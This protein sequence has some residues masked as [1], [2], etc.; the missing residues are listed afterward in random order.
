MSEWKEVKL[1]DVCEL[2][3]DCPHSTAPDEGHGYPLIRT[4][5]IGKGRLI[6]D[7]V[8]RVSKDIFDTRNA[9]AVPKPYDLIFAREATAGNVAQIQEGQEVCLGQRTVL[10]RPNQSIV[11]SSFLT[12]LLLAP[13]QQ[14]NLVSSANGA[15]VA[16]VNLPTIRNLKISIPELPLQKKLGSILASYD[17]LI[18]NYQRQIK[19]LEEAAQRLYKEW[20]VDLHFPGYENTKIVDGVPEGWRRDAKLSSIADIIMGQSPKSEF[21]NDKKI[22]LPFHQGVG[23]Y[24]DR[25]VVNNTY[26]SQYTRI[27][28]KNSILFSVRAPVGRIN[29]NKEKNCNRARL[30]FYQREKWLSKFLVLLAKTYVFQRQY[31]WQW[32]YLC[33]DYERATI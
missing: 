10:I 5:N 27:A 32:S 31:H 30:G 25:F 24:G 20:F 19:L 12:Y 21:Y 28:E 6:L 23:S 22:G 13:L 7:G 18:E 17:N 26:S 1:N 9:R 3:V 16:H 15:T 4:P 2:I 29:I 11:D 8:H 14:H 33:I